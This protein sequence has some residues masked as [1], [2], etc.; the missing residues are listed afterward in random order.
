MFRNTA[1]SKLAAS[2]FT[3]TSSSIWAASDRASLLGP[4]GGQRWRRR[5]ATG[6]RWRCLPEEDQAEGEAI[7]P[8]LYVDHTP[9]GS[10]SRR[11]RERL[12]KFNCSFKTAPITATGWQPRHKKSSETPWIL[13]TPCLKARWWNRGGYFQPIY[14]SKKTLSEATIILTNPIIYPMKLCRLLYTEATKFAYTCN[15]FSSQI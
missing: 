5:W 9:L 4:H 12:P 3:F 15:N 1:L 2:T 13:Q 6:Q 8:T 11:R 14:S 7:C 10:N